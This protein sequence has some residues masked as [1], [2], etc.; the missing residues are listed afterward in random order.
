M[1]ELI[2]AHCT[3]NSSTIRAH[4]HYGLIDIWT[5]RMGVHVLGIL[6]GDV[7]NFSIF[8]KVF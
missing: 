3:S 1:D 7:A 8:L 4:V 5:F 2:L 6:K